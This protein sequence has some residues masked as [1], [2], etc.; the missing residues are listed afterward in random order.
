[1]KTKDDDDLFGEEASEDASIM[2]SIAY[3]ES[4]LG[5][6]MG[7]PKQVEHAK[8]TPIKYDVEDVDLKINS[9]H[10]SSIATK[11]GEDLGDCDIKDDDCISGQQKVM[12]ESLKLVDQGN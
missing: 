12:K 4:K 6:Q 10:L 11:A 9:S 2:K 8:N 7:D 3:A 1:M 5:H